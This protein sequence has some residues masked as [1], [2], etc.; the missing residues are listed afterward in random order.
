MIF[1][2]YF[3]L[4]MARKQSFG[5]VQWLSRKPKNI[6]CRKDILI[7]LPFWVGGLNFG[8]VVSK[9]VSTIEFA[10]W[11]TLTSGISCGLPTQFSIPAAMDPHWESTSSKRTRVS[12]SPLQFHPRL[13]YPWAHFPLECL[14]R[15]QVLELKLRVHLWR[16][17]LSKCIFF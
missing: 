16:A 11:R 15:D 9:R 4:H 6:V 8:K 17:E 1:I 12:P 5:A 10:G 2:S 13:F 14:S 7:V 3:F